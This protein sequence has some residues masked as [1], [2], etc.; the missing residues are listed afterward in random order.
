MLVENRPFPFERTLLVYHFPLGIMLMIF[1]GAP[2]QPQ[3]VVTA[4]ISNWPGGLSTL[5]GFNF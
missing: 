2:S 5:V 3:C 1:N 4:A